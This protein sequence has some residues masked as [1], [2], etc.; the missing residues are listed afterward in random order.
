M[1]D[2]LHCPK[3]HAVVRKYS[4]PFPTADVLV[5]H[6]EHGLVLIERGNEPHGFAIP[7]GFVDEGETIEHAA[8]REMKEEIGMDV[9]L[10]G[11]LGVYSHPKR[12]PRFHTMTVTF[13]GSVAHPEQ[14][15]AGDDAAKAAFYPL[16]QLPGKLCFDHDRA[17]EHFKAYLQGKRPLLPCAESWE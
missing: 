4:N 17:V 6:P 5:Y 2:P 10:L 12:D 9:E 8:V 13:V 3:C 16:S 11:I 1:S 7:G 14:L 15:C